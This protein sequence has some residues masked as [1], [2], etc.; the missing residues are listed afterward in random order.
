M[1]STTNLTEQNSIED[2][3]ELDPTWSATAMLRTDTAKKA[4]GIS[5]DEL[6]RGRAVLTMRVR[7]DMVN[8][9]GITHGGMVFTLADTAFAYACNEGAN[10]VVASGVDITFTRAS[11]SGDT[12]TATAVR[13][14]LSG[15]NG[16]YDIT[17]VDQNDQVI[18]EFRGRSFATNN[19]LP[20][21]V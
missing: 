3:I 15:R 10:A 13:R 7:D 8:G 2:R 11:R 21:A 1:S 16:L 6:E 5:I 17:V 9:F 12:L 18:A 14:W 19:P 4:F 20:T